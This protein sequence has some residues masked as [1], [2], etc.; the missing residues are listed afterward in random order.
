MWAR[1]AHKDFDRAEAPIEGGNNLRLRATEHTVE[2][3][4]TDNARVHLRF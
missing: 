2:L 3:E 1:Q 4:W